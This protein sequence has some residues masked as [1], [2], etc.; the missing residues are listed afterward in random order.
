MELKTDVILDSDV[1]N[2]ID[3]QFAIAYMVKNQDRLNI[4]GITI[5]P[6]SPIHNKKVKD[7]SESI[8]RS[9]DEAIH[10]LDL[11]GAY[12]LKNKV[13][14]G[15]RRFLKDEEDIVESEAV[16]F[17]INESKKYD[18]NNRLTIVEIGAITNVA[19]AINKDTSIIER[20]N[21]VWLGGSDYGYY[22]NEEFNMYQDIAAA[23]VSL[24]KAQNITI[25]PCQGVVSHFS[26]TKYELEHQIKGKNELCDFLYNN[27]IEWMEKGKN[28]PDT[29]AKVIWD[30]C[31]IAYLL[32]DNHR[33]MTVIERNLRIPNYDKRTYSDE[34]D[35]KINY[36]CEIKREEL[37]FDLFKK[38][39]I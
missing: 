20:I 18:K 25:L 34:L 29:W 23:R 35:K 12:E 6:F 17:I 27:V 14:K 31:V 10:T 39:S 22:I 4:K 33:F 37:F 1:F 3:D 32:N 26:T 24:L 5:A 11:L 2:E 9:Y 13:Y 28:R 7:E 36:V 38:I 8:D 19:S 21:L 30:V 15:S 16:D